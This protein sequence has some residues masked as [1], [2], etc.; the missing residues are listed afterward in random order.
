VSRE[1]NRPCGHLSPINTLLPENTALNRQR[2]T[3]SLISSSDHS[4]RRLQFSTPQNQKKMS[5]AS[6][7]KLRQDATRFQTSPCD[8]LEP[9]PIAPPEMDHP[10]TM[11]NVYNNANA[12]LETSFPPGADSIL[13]SDFFGAKFAHPEFTMSQQENILRLRSSLSN[14]NSSGAACLSMGS[15][16]SG[17]KF[18]RDGTDQSSVAAA[19]GASP[20]ASSLQNWKGCYTQGVDQESGGQPLCVVPHHQDFSAGISVFDTP[21]ALAT[22]RVIMDDQQPTDTYRIS[23]AQQ[24]RWQQRF[25]DLVAFRNEYGNCCV[26]T[27]WPQNVS[28][29]DM[30]Q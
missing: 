26:P 8:S 5:F 6:I 23:N 9:T 7:M 25:H 16:G 10:P 27:H 3:S 15:M 22:Q 4:L 30:I 17:Q 1:K 21:P 18:E 12:L 20:Q 24:S 14:M 29:T 11:R 13:S 2:R 19:L 28:K